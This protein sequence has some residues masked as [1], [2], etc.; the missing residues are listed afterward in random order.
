L[1]DDLPV[2]LPELKEVK[3]SEKIFRWKNRPG[4]RR[5]ELIDEIRGICVLAMVAYHSFFILGSQFGVA[6]GTNLYELFRP[7]QPAFAA[8][9]IVISGFCARLSRDARKRGFILAALAMA[10]TAVTVLLLPYLGLEDMKVWFGVLHLLAASMLLFSL[11]RKIFDKIPALVGVVLCLALFFLCA[12]VSRGYL[13]AFGFHWELPDSLYRSNALAFLG[14]HTPQ[15]RAF[16]HFPLLPYSFLFLFGT[17]MGK[18]AKN[19]KG[20]NEREKENLPEFCYKKHLLFF[21]FLGRHALPLYL[22]HIPVFYGLAY[23]VRVLLSV[24]S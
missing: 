17:F 11:C 18:M 10:V 4:A 6:W 13:G 15:F 23:V 16:D 8:M 5:I 3:D 22:L 2:D 14:F 12:P 1:A 7:A 9:F 20:E 19:E 24:T 21:G